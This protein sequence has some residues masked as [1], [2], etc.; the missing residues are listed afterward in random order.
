MLLRD[1]YCDIYGEDPFGVRFSLTPMP[2][3]EIESVEDIKVL[4]EIGA[5]TPDLS[6]R[7]SRVLVGEDPF[8][9]DA[10]RR[11]VQAKN[12]SKTVANTGNSGNAGKEAG[13]GK[14]KN[15]QKDVEK[16]GKDQQNVKGGKDQ[17][18]RGLNI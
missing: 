4:H 6:L 3:L 10:K 14:E 18:E 16:A 5:L 13:A 12:E 15:V 8:Q 17:T 11:K 9:N 2:R 7:L 1:V